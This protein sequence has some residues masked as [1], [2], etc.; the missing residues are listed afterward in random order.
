MGFIAS[1]VPAV[2]MAFGTEIGKN[3]LAIPSRNERNGFQ[4]TQSGGQEKVER[5][6]ENEYRDAQPND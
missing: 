2:G 3:S 1:P 5:L 4:S 6:P